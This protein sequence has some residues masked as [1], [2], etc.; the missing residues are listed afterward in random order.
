MK[1]QENK[2]P[3]PKDSKLSWSDAIEFLER[4]IIHKDYI[5]QSRLIKALDRI[6]AG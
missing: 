4:H 2:Q 5:S 3:E 1:T 6:K